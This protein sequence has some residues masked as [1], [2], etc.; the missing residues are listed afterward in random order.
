MAVHAQ[1]ANADAAIRGYMAQRSCHPEEAD[2][3]DDE[4]N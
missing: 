2:D 4:N 3:D 1:T